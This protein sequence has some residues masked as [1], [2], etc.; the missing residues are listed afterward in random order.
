MIFV[1]DF[2][3]IKTCTIHDF[4]PDPCFLFFVLQNIVGYEN[5]IKRG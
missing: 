5:D 1:Q 2:V 4:S 3:P